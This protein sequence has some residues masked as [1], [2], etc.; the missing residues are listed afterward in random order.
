MCIR[1]S[2]IVDTG[3]EKLTLSSGEVSIKGDFYR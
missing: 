2:L 1:D 3:E